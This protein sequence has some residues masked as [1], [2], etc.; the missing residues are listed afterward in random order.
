MSDTSAAPEPAELDQPMSMEGEDAPQDQPQQE[1]ELPQGEIAV[2]APS[3][4]GCKSGD[5]RLQK[6]P[7]WG[8]TAFDDITIGD[9]ES[10]V[11]QN[12]ALLKKV[13]ANAEAAQQLKELQSQKKALEKELVEVGSDEVARVKSSIS[14]QLYAQMLWHFSWN[15]ELKEGRSISAWVPNVSP[16]LLKA[17]GGSTSSNQQR[18]ASSYFEKAL[19]RVVSS[20]RKNEQPLQSGLVLGANVTLKY[21]KTT[22]ELQVDTTY[23]FGNPE[24]TKTTNKQGKKVG[25]KA[26][27]AVGEE[28]EEAEADEADNDA[29]EEEHG[30]ESLAPACDDKV[31]VDGEVGAMA[32]GGQ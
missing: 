13:E 12:A 21:F 8:N 15:A 23:K 16:E 31:A 24:K 6:R 26:K 2:A 19:A 11:R 32:I 1:D 29:E 7:R 20:T 18:R 14:K 27:K 17:L 10:I 25:R 22:S 9:V 30:D 28:G 4:R 5:D 3:K